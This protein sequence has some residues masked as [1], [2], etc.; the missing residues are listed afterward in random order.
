[1][2]TNVRNAA[3]AAMGV[4]VLA[5]CASQGKPPPVI[6]LDDPA[7]IKAT[8]AP[9]DPPV[10]VEVVAVP[11][12]LPLPGQ[13]KALPGGNEVKAAPESSDETQRV[14]RANEEARILA[15]SAIVA[16]TVLSTLCCRNAP[17]PPAIEAFT[18]LVKPLKFA[19]CVAATVRPFARL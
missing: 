15:L 9:S 12:P 3:L 17:L 14:S 11:Q 2:K 4:V 19:V 5:G 16:F 1:M 10:P 13:L 18:L 7:G 6:A 8:H